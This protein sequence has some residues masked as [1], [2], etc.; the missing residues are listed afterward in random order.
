MLSLRVILATAL[1]SSLCLSF[2]YDRTRNAWWCTYSLGA[3]NFGNGKCGNKLDGV[4]PIDNLRR[5][6]QTERFSFPGSGKPQL[7]TREISS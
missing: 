2:L 5:I 6:L 1:R 7:G 4:M 3:F